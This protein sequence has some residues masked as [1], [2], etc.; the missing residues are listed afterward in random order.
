MTKAGKMFPGCGEV[1]RTVDQSL[2]TLRSAYP[3]EGLCAGWARMGQN[4]GVWQ[5]R[6]A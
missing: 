3:R 1:D 5:W 6:E 4:S 2:F